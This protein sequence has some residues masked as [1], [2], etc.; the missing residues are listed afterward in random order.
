[1]LFK[2]CE[3]QKTIKIH[4]NVVPYYA[5]DCVWSQIQIIARFILQLHN[6]IPYIFLNILSKKY[7]NYY[8]LKVLLFWRKSNKMGRHIEFTRRHNDYNFVFKTTKFISTIYGSL[9]LLFCYKHP[10]IWTLVKCTCRFADELIY[11]YRRH[12]KWSLRV[13]YGGWKGQH[14]GLIK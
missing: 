3:I 6:I 8:I 12:W 2:P 10:I 14:R 5:S 11:S 4:I 13:I 7:Y 1:M 9:L